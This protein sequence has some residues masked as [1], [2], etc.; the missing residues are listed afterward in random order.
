MKKH[1]YTNA[2]IDETSP[3][4][5]QHAHNPVNWY[6]WN[7]TT[8]EKAKQENKLL[9][10]SIGYSACHWCHVMEHE[11][12]EDDSVAAIMNENFIC[13]KV[14]REERPD[15]DQIYMTALH[16]MNQRGGWPLN[17][18]AIPDGKPF[19]G[20]T[21]FQKEDWKEQIIQIANAYEQNPSQII[22]FA[23]RL[24]EGIQEV[25]NVIMNQK[26]AEF[27]WQE[28][29]KMVLS[30]SER[31]D[32][33]DGGSEGAPKFPMP[34][35]YNFL[36]K[37][38][39][40]ADNKECLDHIEI[41]LEKLAYGGIYDHIGGGFA[42]Y[43]VDRL[44]KVPHF[45]KMLYDNAQLVSLYSEAYLKF[46]NPLYKE[47][48]IETLEFVER[49]LMADEGAFFSALDADSEGEEGKFY[50]WKEDDLKRIIKHD[51]PIF[52]QHFNI[53]SNG[54]WEHGN[55]IL[56]RKESKEQIASIHEIDLEE[57]DNK[58][59][60]WKKILLKERSKRVRPGLDDKSLT[61]WNGL[62]LQ[63]YLD[64]YFSFNNKHYLDIAL[65][66]ANFIVNQQM[67][68]NGKLMHSYKAG[69]STINGYLEDYSIVASAFI[70]LYQATYDEK[71]LQYCDKLIQYSITHFYD[72]ESGM[73]FF[74]SNLDPKLVARKMEVTDNVIPASNSV[75]ANALFDLGVLLDNSK[76]KNKA[77]IMLNNVKPDMS[78]FGY[79]NYGT[80]ML[81]YLE[82][83]YEIA[84]VGNQ[85]NEKTIEFNQ[86]Y[87]PNKIFLGSNSSLSKMELLE[88]KYIE[89]KTMIYVCEN[90][91]CQ[92]P[93]DNINEAQKLLK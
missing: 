68:D 64:A 78:Y 5:L 45:E 25:E 69:K 14:D 10:I 62:M 75:M 70:K 57:L 86:E 29:D 82:P 54:F 72:Q 31:F 4:L 67:D 8:L 7:E 27:S 83:F 85:A 33:E 50:I 49:E 76:Y 52:K 28:L 24:S 12:F 36:L 13:V 91:V 38:A 20:G 6:P 43:S 87:H 35:S 92:L 37:Y 16:L 59:K 44:W 40:L 74:T 26:K 48:V 77:K 84:I 3:Y 60:D 15:V 55:Y 53:N 34:N 88:N 65:K 46:K 56:L 66:N 39:H 47:V 30:M 61:S 18:I 79:S 22:E 2:L 9:L 1:K 23:N 19:W 51:Y 58:I 11:T 93:T 80:L 21:Y 90:K 71:W 89:G 41:T 63:A 81:K 32:N 42:R 17:C 73:F